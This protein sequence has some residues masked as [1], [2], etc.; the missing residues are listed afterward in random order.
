MKC[1]IILSALVTVF[2]ALS[3]VGVALADNPHTT[4]G[5]TGQPN[6]EA[7]DNPALK[8]PGFSTSGFANAE[9]HYAGS[10]LNPNRGNTDKAVSQYDVAGFQW[11][12]HHST[13]PSK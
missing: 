5:S 4:P 7:S 3:P 8:P 11:E 1:A 13:T 12:Q 10:D 6:K 2:V 9:Q